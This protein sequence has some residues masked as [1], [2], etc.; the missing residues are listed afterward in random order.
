MCLDT[1]SKRKPKPEGTGWKVFREYNGVLYGEFQNTSKVCPVGKW[2]KENDY[3]S[4]GYKMS[5]SGPSYLLGWHVFKR[6]KDAK[7]WMNNLR[8]VV[9]KVEYRK[10]HTQGKQEMGPIVSPI[11]LSCIVAKEIK[12]LPNG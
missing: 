7:K 2:L 9:R 10:A 8:R 5:I 4:V 6:K 12:I 3:K 1:V 11:I